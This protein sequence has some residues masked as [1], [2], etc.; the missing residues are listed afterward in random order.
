MR[1]GDVVNAVVTAVGSY[2]A[3]VQ[4]EDGQDGFL[5]WPEI[6]WIEFDC[7]PRM[8]EDIL[9]IGQK[10]KLKVY[11][12]RADGKFSGSI[13]QLEEDGDPWLKISTEQVGSYVD[14]EILKVC[15]WGL[16]VRH[17]VNISVWC[18]F[19]SGESKTGYAVGEMV[20]IT[21]EAIDP[22]QGIKGKIQSRKSL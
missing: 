17:P 18:R 19:S 9:K 22:N 12:F 2:G 21:I 10:I 4:T 16:I 20:G 13:R 1:I 5:H 7:D 6:S 14:C 15:E 11:G 8:P 3:Y